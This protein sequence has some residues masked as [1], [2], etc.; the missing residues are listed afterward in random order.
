MCE[1]CEYLIFDVVHTCILPH[2]YVQFSY[3]HTH[4]L[5][6]NL[7]I[8]LVIHPCRQWSYIDIIIAIYT[9]Q[10]A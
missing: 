8:V 3:G 10:I 5:L 9:L 7:T 2:M 4:W 6:D 1:R